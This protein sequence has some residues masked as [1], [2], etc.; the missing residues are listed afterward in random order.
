MWLIARKMVDV[1]IQ[2][3]KNWKASADLQKWMGV[4]SSINLSIS[5]NSPQN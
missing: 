3:M 5:L 1:Q 4:G 2:N